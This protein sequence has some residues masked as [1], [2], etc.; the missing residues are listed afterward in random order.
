MTYDGT[1]DIQITCRSMSD[2]VCPP[3]ARA[4]LRGK[5]SVQ[6]DGKIAGY[7]SSRPTRE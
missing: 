6:Q 3:S 4:C 5:E 7:T 1:S 2:G